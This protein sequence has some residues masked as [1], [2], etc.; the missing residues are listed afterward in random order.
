MI[1]E[2]L[3]QSVACSPEA[4]KHTTDKSSAGHLAD[5]TQF[6][7]MQCSVLSL[8]W[9]AWYITRVLA[10]FMPKG[11]ILSFLATE[12]ASEKVNSSTH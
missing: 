3:Q 7:C 6:Q 4:A 9:A 10:K 5:V 11:A 8:H 2:D 1:E 12:S